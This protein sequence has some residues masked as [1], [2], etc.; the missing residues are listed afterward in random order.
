M[1]VLHVL[2]QVMNSSMLTISWFHTTDTALLL[3]VVQIDLGHVTLDLEGG[4][5]QE[6]PTGAH[7][8]RSSTAPQ[9][10]TQ[11]Q[12]GMLCGQFTANGAYADVQSYPDQQEARER[13][14][15]PGCR[16]G[17]M[18]TILPQ[19]SRSCC[20]LEWCS[21]QLLQSTKKHHEQY[22]L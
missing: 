1:S 4:F 10:S 2:L 16:V 6:Q 19:T 12:T 18:T 7:T 5:L 15:T 8:R 3:V 13:C 20:R 14:Y 22:M 17:M 21:L 9:H 11:T